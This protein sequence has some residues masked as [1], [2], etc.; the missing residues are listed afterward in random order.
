MGI[1][2]RRRTKMMIIVPIEFKTTIYWSSKML[3]IS[4][5]NNIL[6]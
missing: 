1:Q 3:Y 5:I 2:R 4:P 6:E